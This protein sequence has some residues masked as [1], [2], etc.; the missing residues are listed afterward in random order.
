MFTVDKTVIKGCYEQIE[1]I[2]NNHS[3]ALFVKNCNR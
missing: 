1:M 3:I 2:K